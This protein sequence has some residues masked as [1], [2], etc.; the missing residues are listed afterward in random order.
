MT[1]TFFETGMT[2]ID[3]KRILADWPETN[4]YGEPS[5]VWLTNGSGVSNQAKAIIPL[6]IRYHGNEVSADLMLSSE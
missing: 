3:L 5:E 1:P 2:V 4:E 6:G